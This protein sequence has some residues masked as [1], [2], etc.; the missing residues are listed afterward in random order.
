MWWLLVIF[1]GFPLLIGA[2]AQIQKRRHPALDVSKD[3]DDFLNDAHPFIPS[4]PWG[5]KKRLR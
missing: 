5:E 4:S 2:V 3:P 1:F